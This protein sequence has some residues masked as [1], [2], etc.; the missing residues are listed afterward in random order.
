MVRGPVRFA[1]VVV[2]ALASG[3]GPAAAQA[4]DPAGGILGDG[5]RACLQDRIGAAGPADTADDR[6][7][8]TVSFQTCWQAAALV[9]DCPQGRLGPCALEAQGQVVAARYLAAARAADL[10]ADLRRLAEVVTGLNRPRNR[11]R[12]RADHGAGTAPATDD[13]ED[14]RAALAAGLVADAT[15]DAIFGLVDLAVVEGLL[16]HAGAAR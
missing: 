12:C 9:A 2:A 15:C 7:R 6:L 10:P 1:S 5:F 8:L 4:A 11:D 16:L 13:P 14:L 3:G